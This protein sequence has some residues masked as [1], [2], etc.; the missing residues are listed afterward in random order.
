MK[1]IDEYEMVTKKFIRDRLWYFDSD[2]IKD[3]IAKYECEIKK[4]CRYMLMIHDMR[5]IKL[6]IKSNV[7]FERN[8]DNIILYE[9]DQFT[10]TKMVVVNLEKYKALIKENIIIK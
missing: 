1:I 8:N 9:S 5:E 6:I 4:K 10:K 7:F 3:F 2:V